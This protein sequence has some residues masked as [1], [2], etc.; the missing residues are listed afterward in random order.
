[1]GTS[2][3]GPRA[4]LERAREHLDALGRELLPFSKSTTYPVRYGRDPQTNEHVWR[5][6]PPSV[7]I[8]VSLLAG[9]AL[10]NLRSALDHL[11]WQLV[12]ANGNTPTK[13]NEFPIF[14]NPDKY[15]KEVETKLRGVSKDAQHVIRGVQ[16]F[17]QED[18][19]LFVLHELD[20]VDK[21]RHLNLVVVS[22]NGGNIRSSPLISVEEFWRRATFG[23]V[24]GDT[25]LLRLPG[26]YDD[27]EFRPTFEVR[28]GDVPGVTPETRMFIVN[29]S[30]MPVMQRVADGVGDIF[31]ELG[32]QLSG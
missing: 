32:K 24:T 19:V 25:V 1:M 15:D 31:L 16:P 4:K 14:D 12:L 30:L 22:T 20:I 29:F 23:P 8:R 7:P 3:E 17:S 5:I 13:T 27:V 21:H 11:V 2:L 18:S 6:D 9:D 26:H 28:F 10:H